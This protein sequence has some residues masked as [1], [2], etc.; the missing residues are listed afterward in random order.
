M[1]GGEQCGKSTTAIDV[2][3]LSQFGALNGYHVAFCVPDEAAVTVAKR[4]VF[5]LIHH[6][7]D[8][9]PDRPRVEL[10]TGGSI[11]F[12]RLDDEH[13]ELWDH[14]ALIV[15][16]DAQLVPRIEPLW[17]DVL[18]PALGRSRGSAWIFGKPRGAR[19]GFASLARNAAG[20]VLWA[21]YRMPT[22]ENPYFDR[23]RLEAD[24]EKFT[25]DQFAQERE[26]VFVDVPVALTASQ[27]IIKPGETFREWCIR[28]GEEGLHV[29]EKP[30]TLDD[31]PAMHFVY[32]LIPS[33]A[34]EAFQRIDVIMKCTQVGFTVFEMMAML[35]LALRFAPAKIGS[36]MP[37]KDLA[38]GK[39]SNRFM[40]IVRTMPAVHS[41][42]T[43]TAAEHGKSG[44][45]NVLTRNLGNS[46]FYFLWTSGKTTTESNPMDVVS[47]DE[48]QEMKIAAMEKTR[49]RMSASA[50]RY[51]LM[52]STANW[53]D[54]DI[55]WWFKK[56]TQYQ[57]HTD[58]PSCHTGQVLDDH[59]PKCV[60]FD[61][62]ALR[63]NPREA[64]AGIVGEYRYRCHACGGW[65]DDP[66]IGRWIA[67]FPEASI[68]SLHF[69][70]FLS[71]TISPREMYEAYR[72]AKDMKNFYNRK[73][74]KPYVDP[75]QVP[76][77][78]EMLAAC[79]ALGMKLGV[80]WEE[81]GR[82]TYMGIDQMGQFNAVLI[83]KRLPTGHMAIIHAEEVY[84]ADPFARCSVLLERY[85]VR[86]CVVETLPNYNDAKRFANRHPGIVFLAGYGNME[87]DMLRW[88]DDRANRSERR[89][90]DEDRDQYTV[91]LDQYKSMQV[92][93]A[94]ISKLVC[95]FP[96]P[97]ALI[98][99]LTD[100][101]D[102]GKGERSLRPILEERVFK[103]F[104][105]TAL[106][107]ER[108]EE[109][110]KFR[111]RVV[112]VG[113]DPHFS[114]AF[115][116]LNVAWARAHG[117]A[118]FLFPDEA[119]E[120]EVPQGSIAIAQTRVLADIKRETEEAGAEKCAGCASF[121]EERG[122]CE[123][124][125]VLVRPSSP[126]C[127]LFMDR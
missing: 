50:I 24:R 35:Y 97:K 13:L 22:E 121:D 29:D 58:C 23:A 123:E 69:P 106:I 53:P 62:T 95:V 38:A 78:L 19:D 77:N 83:A 6:L 109:E 112:K 52:G 59:F 17:Y 34:E 87:S 16:D 76:V 70:Q 45:G 14:L 93:F 21:A 7:V 47:F 71:P 40:G 73:L 94:R 57:F 119:E 60:G 117:T 2:L 68:R 41:M 72:D 56:G 10:I 122:W 114:Y 82:D 4:R 105:R 100:D 96:D 86:V 8:G 104:T 1:H 48:V 103:H 39:S 66:Q 113:I 91:T 108:D 81:R 102:N 85:G 115:M 26:G 74:G 25:A 44:E 107:A 27:S 43:E 31:R 64:E 33:T 98:Q 3:L 111:R 118:S 99:E 30:F 46:I 28:L 84:D 65:I 49:E 61:P 101:G 88:G 67:K 37:S 18:E 42:M 9:R 116:L 80:V 92:A 125:E 32:D 20:G 11:R 90:D 55:H 12:V 124:R 127:I 126:A 36:F 89:T 51:T 120:V 110:K 15:V 75:T 5:S 79:A 54:E 63:W